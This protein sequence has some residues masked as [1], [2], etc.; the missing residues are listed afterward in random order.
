VKK[1]IDYC[2]ADFPRVLL[3]AVHG[4]AG[5]RLGLE[6]IIEPHLAKGACHTPNGQVVEPVLIAVC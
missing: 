4:A 6:L 2:Y 5:S 3:E 1:G